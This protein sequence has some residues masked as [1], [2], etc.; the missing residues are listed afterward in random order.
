M[1]YMFAFTMYYGV[2]TVAHHDLFTS[3][4]R[5]KAVSL[6]CPFIDCFEERGRH[7]L[8]DMLIRKVNHTGVTGLL[9]QGLKDE[10]DKALVTKSDQVQS[11]L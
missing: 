11:C 1:L 9:I 5:Q 8:F 6:L 7:K 2:N 3:I 4:Q 10:V